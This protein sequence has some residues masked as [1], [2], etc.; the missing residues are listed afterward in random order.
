MDPIISR[1]TPKG[2]IEIGVEHGQFWARVGGKR[3]SLSIAG[4]ER[5]ADMGER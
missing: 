5:V 2:Q 4:I 3:V 1:D